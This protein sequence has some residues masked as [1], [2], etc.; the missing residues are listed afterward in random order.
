MLQ[1]RIPQ[2]SGTAGL[3][4]DFR[5]AQRAPVPQQVARPDPASGSEPARWPWLL[6]VAGNML[7]GGMLL[8]ALLAAPI[9]AARLLGLA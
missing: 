1:Q 6:E 9:V 5:Q 4:F 2:D 7:G 3:K 8:A